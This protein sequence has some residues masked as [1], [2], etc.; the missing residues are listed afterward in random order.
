MTV[1]LNLSV[2][3]ERCTGHCCREFPIGSHTIQDL[4]DIAADPNRVER[5][6]AA[7]IIDMLVPLG[8]KPDKDGRV[9]PVYT[10]RHLDAT[11][12]DCR[13]YKGRPRMC[14]DYPYGNPC[15]HAECTMRMI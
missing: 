15:E 6:E 4:R 1:K 2:I 13:N 9:R 8:E 11:T 12:G 10:C 7:N 5:G 3:T 14:R